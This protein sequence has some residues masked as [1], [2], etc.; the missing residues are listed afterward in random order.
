MDV[1]VVGYPALLCVP[2]FFPFLLWRLLCFLPFFLVF[3]CPLGFVLLSGVAV[4]LSAM[5]GLAVSCVFGAV[6]FLRLSFRFAMLG[7]CVAS[8]GVKF[9][10]C[11]SLPS[12]GGGLFFQ[13]LER[14]KMIDALF[15][16]TLMAGAFLSGIL[17]GA[18]VASWLNRKLGG[19]S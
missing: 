12:G 16:L 13:Q 19:D 2:P 17:V 8:S 4:V 6:F 15:V 9:P 18:P 7:S 14:W 10:P 5:F 1:C 11:P 3:F